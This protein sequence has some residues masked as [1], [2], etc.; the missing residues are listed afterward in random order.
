M[1]IAKGDRVATV[2]SDKVRGT[3]VSIDRKGETAQVVWDT[4]PLKSISPRPRERV[5]MGHRVATLVKVKE[6]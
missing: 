5:P 2:W 1:T 4:A 3:V 6:E